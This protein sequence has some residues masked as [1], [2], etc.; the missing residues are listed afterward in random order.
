MYDHSL[1]AGGIDVG[2]LRTKAVGADDAGKPTIGKL[3]VGHNSPNVLS[4]R[5][6]NRPRDVPDIVS[7]GSGC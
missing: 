1:E 3:I 4:C 7:R 5:R 6:M 2:S